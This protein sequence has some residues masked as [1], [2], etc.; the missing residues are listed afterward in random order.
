MIYQ[1]LEVANTLIELHE[2][3]RGGDVVDVLSHSLFG[4]ELHSKCKGFVLALNGLNHVITL[5]GCD[6]CD[7]QLSSINTAH[8][9]MMP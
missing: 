8:Y 7:L 4:M 1:C 3:T 2:L 6:A 5:C 9:L